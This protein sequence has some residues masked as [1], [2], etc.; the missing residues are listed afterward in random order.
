MR[1]ILNISLPSATVKM[2]KTEVKKGG[3]ASVS[4]FMRHLIRLW[5]T[6]KLVG[7]VKQSRKEFA[8]GKGKVLKSLKDL[9]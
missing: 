3:Y 6:E 5:N 2:I 9:T 4:E 7:D 1:Q 8:D